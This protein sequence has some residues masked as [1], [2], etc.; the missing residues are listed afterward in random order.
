MKA[1][2]RQ[3][4]SI[5]DLFAIRLLDGTYSIG[6]VLDVP[7]PNVA[8]C[9]FFDQLIDMPKLPE[10]IHIA[11]DNII[12]TASVVP[13][14]LDR[15]VWKV[16]ARAPVVLAPNQWPNEKTRNNSWVGAKVHS[17]AIVEDFLNAYRGLLPWDDYHDPE[18]LDKLLFSPSKKPTQLV[19]KNHAKNIV[20]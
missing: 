19:Y 9:A 1:N 12:G 7:M 3:Q 17:G 6:Q 8:S 10:P 13:A 18:Y 11:V 20:K 15:S 5:G 2:H 4:W 16:F 14:H